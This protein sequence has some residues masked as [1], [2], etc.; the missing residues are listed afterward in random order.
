[1]KIF[2][3]IHE[4]ELHRAANTG[5]IAIDDSNEIFQRILFQRVPPNKGLTKLIENN[6]A[7]LLYSK[8]ESSSTIIQEYENIVII[9]GT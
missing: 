8:G 7:L 6:E 4:R 1:M 3:L 9:D 2:L 5:S